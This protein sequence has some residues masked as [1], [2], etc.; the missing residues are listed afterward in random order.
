M[1]SA[2]MV[3]LLYKGERVKGWTDQR[4]KDY[5]MRISHYFENE[6]VSRNLR[7]MTISTTYVETEVVRAGM[8]MIPFLVIG[9]G[10]MAVCSTLTV[11]LSA[12]YMQ[13]VSIHKVSL[14]VTAC[15]CPMMACGTALGLLF[16]MGVRF[17]SILCVTPFLVL[18]IGCDDA[19][20]MIHAWQLVSK[21]MQKNPD[22][23]DSVAYRL[24][25]VLI[26][27]GP[28]ILIS[29]LTNILADAVGSV[30]GSPEITLLCIGNMAAIFVDFIYQIT[31]YSAIMAI[32]A[33]Y[34][35][36][37]EALQRYNLSITIGDPEFAKN[38]IVSF[39]P[40]TQFH[41]NVKEKFHKF[42]SGYVAFITN[43]ITATTVFALWIAFIAVSLVG[44]TR[45][46]V[47][48]TTKKLYPQD[49]PLLEVW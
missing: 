49:S 38:K 6:F 28:A 36:R 35:M 39:E 44:I 19:Y 29:A 2:E 26:D 20:L 45:F 46:E 9:F 43:T 37:K 21:R 12:T 7:V 33:K 1:E 41:D 5:E 27:T 34:E 3:A 16:M 24:S 32:A 42:V 22:K 14:A 25:L 8:S 47:N 15:I 31:F 23:E 30:T 18:A 10:I 17:G 40:N 4:I 48:L 13:Q 11:L